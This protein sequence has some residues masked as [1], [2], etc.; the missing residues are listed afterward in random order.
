MKV[1]V[2]TREINEY[3]QDGEYFVAVFKNKPTAIQ[4]KAYI[5][6]NRMHNQLH[7]LEDVLENL[8]LTGGGRLSYE[9]EWFF[10]REQ[11]AA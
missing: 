8:L 2:L 11:E 10:L 7:S 1:W 3:E 5:S 4:L 6:K 9:D